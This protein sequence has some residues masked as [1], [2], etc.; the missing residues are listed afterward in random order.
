MVCQ[1]AVRF[2][3][4]LVALARG[5]FSSVFADLA[6]VVVSRLET[7][8]SKPEWGEPQMDGLGLYPVSF[9]EGIIWTQS[10]CITKH[11]VAFWPYSNRTSP[12]HPTHS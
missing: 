1:V 8:H 4:L 3:V 9:E 2:P 11:L 5:S 7:W 6:F 12:P 10:Y